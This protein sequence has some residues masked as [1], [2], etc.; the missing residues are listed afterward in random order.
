MNM[1][2]GYTR[3]RFLKGALFLV[4]VLIGVGSLVYTN[5]LVRKLEND[6]RDKIQRIV[7]A[8]VK[9]TQ[10]SEDSDLLGF[11][12][13][14]IQEKHTIPIIVTDEA[15]N[16]NMHRNI[17]STKAQ[18]STYLKQRLERM[19]RKRQPIMLEYELG[20]YHS[21]E[22][23]Y[24]DD[25]Q[26]ITLLRYYPWIQ[27]FVIALFIGVAYFAFS[28]SRKY[29]QNQVWVGMSKETA[30]QL[31]TPLSSLMAWVEYLRSHEGPLEHSVIDELDKDVNRLEVITERFSK[32]GSKPELIKQNIPEVIEQNLAYLRTR[33]SR[34]VSLYIDPV[35]DQHVFAP[36]S[37][38][39]FEWVIENLCKNAVD[40]M[41]GEGELRFLIKD[42][43]EHVLIDV[44][45]TGRGIPLLM[46][47]TV[48]KAG[49][50]TRKRGWGLGLSLAKRII[51]SYHYGS[52]FVLSSELGKG[53]TF[54]IKL[55]KELGKS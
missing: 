48:F 36:I 54:R 53:T 28:S 52:I 27:F 4:A 3:K 24:Y 51:E 9:I 15:G 20:D 47:K 45:D 10:V 50:T 22:F 34:K 11:L 12:S 49:Y 46:Q 55:S 39:L 38:S 42:K 8:T 18:D 7:D 23:F 33:V 32:I 29:E 40:A 14:I 35:S 26:I 31:G 6:E 41:A 44:S 5:Y 16:I 21:K 2:I 37:T 25:S 13:D 17:D 1:S 19:K 43:G 30:H